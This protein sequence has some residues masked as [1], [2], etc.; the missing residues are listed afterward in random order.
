MSLLNGKH[1]LLGVCGSIAAYKAAD[2]ASKLTQQGAEVQVILTSSAE[3]FV[4]PLTFSSL[5]GQPVFTDGALWG[6]QAHVLHVGL[7]HQAQALLVA[8]CSANTLAKLAQGQ[9][10]NLLTITALAAAHLPVCLAPA[11]DAGMYEHPAT[12]ANVAVLRGRGVHF[13][14]P[15]PGRMASGL[16]GLGRMMEPAEILERLN[17]VL[18][19]NGPLRGKRLL[20]TAGGSQQPIDP[21]RY[22]ANRSSGRQG[23]ALAQAALEAG[24]EVTLLTH[25]TALPAPVGAQVQVLRTAQEMLDAL[26]QS[27]PGHDA[28]LM[29]AAVADFQ[30]KKVA[31][32]KLKKRDGI[33]TLE[34]EA[35]PD[36]LAEIARLRPQL[37]RLKAVIGFAAESR[38][39]LQN[40]A[41]KLQAK[42]L[43]FIAANDISAAD[44]G[45]AVETNRITL[46]YPDARQET[47]PLLTKLEAAQVII[48]RVADILESPCES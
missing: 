24:A 37:P 46:L 17:L 32:H 28:L 43:D 40:A 26:R 15:V 13:F 47:L 35:A 25:P 2:L 39:L 14:G 31:A 19:Q 29:A 36:I 4:A 3:R 10:D 27:L 45:F 11:M 18:A 22:I 42:R 8:P 12:Q 1:I 21:V 16:S 30:V 20:I 5:T 33:P 48:Q 41:A 44:A 7:A 6:A 9:A 34:L 38:D 23:Y